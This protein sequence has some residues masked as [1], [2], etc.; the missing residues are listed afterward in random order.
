MKIIRIIFTG[1]VAQFPGVMLEELRE[2]I[3]M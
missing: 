1:L 3:K 2:Q